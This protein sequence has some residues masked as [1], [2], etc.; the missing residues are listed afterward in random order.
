MSKLLQAMAAVAILSITSVSGAAVYDNPDEPTPTTLYFH[1]WDT[2]SKFVIN[3]EPYNASFFETGGVNFPTTSGTPAAQATGEWDF[4]TIYG[5]STA[6][7]V[8]YDFNENG[9]PRLHPERGI[10]NDVELT[11]EYDHKVHL[12]IDAR[13][14]GGGDESPGVLPEMNFRVTMREGDQP[15]SDL[16]SGAKI[17]E[18][19][20]KVALFDTMFCPTDIP[21]AIAPVSIFCLFSVD[22][23][24]EAGTYDSYPQET[25]DG[26]PILYPDEN[27][28]IEVIIDMALLQDSIK[29]SDA[30]NVR[31]DWYQE[32]PAATSGPDQF[33]LGN[34][35]MVLDEQ[36][37]PRLNTSITNPVYIEFLH[38]QVAAGT[39]LIH[40]GINSPWGTYDLDFDSVKVDV[41]G[42]TAP[43]ELKRV[44]TSNTNVHGLHDQAAEITYLWDFREDNAVNGD[45]EI[46]YSVMN[47]DNTATA[48]ASDSFRIDGKKLYT[49]DDQGEE[50]EFVDD[51]ASEESPFGALGLTI[52]GLA[53]LALRRRP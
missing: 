8:E 42:P 22:P 14:I 16:D 49:T 2:F 11:A 41:V 43:S 40:S 17:M 29:K 9:R 15:G 21:S 39:L 32:P 53:A 12:Y 34:L 27:N 28:V 26:T 3:T 5:F 37:L 18:G 47:A 23:S 38:P 33:A 50:I 31:M 52:I 6:G 10:A 4:N 13:G 30:Y 44:T 36:Y 7:P 51:S 35:R 24:Q 46:T 19:Q 25:P 48:V 45:Y 20:V 1:I